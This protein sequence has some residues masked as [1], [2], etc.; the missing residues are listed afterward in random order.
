VSVSFSIIPDITYRLITVSQIWHPF[1]VPCL[2]TPL[3][4][5][6]LL[7]LFCNYPTI[8]VLNVWTYRTHTAEHI[9]TQTFR[10]C[11]YSWMNNTS[12]CTMLN[13]LERKTYHF[14]QYNFNTLLHHLLA[15]VCWHRIWLVE[16]TVVAGGRGT[17]WETSSARMKTI[18]W[19]HFTRL[20]HISF[21]LS[22]ALCAS[23]ML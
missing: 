9:W 4:T 11:L 20:L 12:P 6:F 5:I 17:S 15:S 10:H 1:F 18:W 7:H 16:F 19:L 23:P 14:N 22:S 8:L 3:S 13:N 21:F 2:L